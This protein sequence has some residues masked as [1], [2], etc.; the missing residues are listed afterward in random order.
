SWDRTV[1]LWDPAA[2]QLVATLPGH[3][4][5][6]LCAAFSPDGKLLATGGGR[7]G[8]ANYAPGPGEVKV[9]DVASRRCLDTLGDHPDRVF[10]VAFAPDGRTLAS[11]SWDGTVKRRHAADRAEWATLH[12]PD[13]M[14]VD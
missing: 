3:T 4:L 9:W 8:D 10:S 13:G 12:V 11:V 7:W 14:A 2:G 1:K 5:P 6:V